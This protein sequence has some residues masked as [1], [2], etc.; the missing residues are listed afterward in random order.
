M[1]ISCSSRRIKTSGVRQNC[2]AYP[3]PHLH[4]TFA[5]WSKIRA[6]LPQK[7]PI[8]PQNERGELPPALMALFLFFA[9]DACINP[10]GLT[11]SAAN[12]LISD[13]SRETW[14]EY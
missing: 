12:L 7:R 4:G 14:H 2:L 10:S 11:T 3:A 13:R 9:S 8:R 6:R 5:V 1:Y